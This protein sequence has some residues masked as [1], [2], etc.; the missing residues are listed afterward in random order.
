[1]L[2]Q[3]FTQAFATKRIDKLDEKPPKEDGSQGST[4]K[5]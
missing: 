4:K 2:F 1:M 3:A 5:S